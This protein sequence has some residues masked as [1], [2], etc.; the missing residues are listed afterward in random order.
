M[1]ASVLTASIGMRQVAEAYC[2][3]T[4]YQALCASKHPGLG[5]S[6]AEMLQAVELA[7]ALSGL[8][9]TSKALTQYVREFLAG[10]TDD[11]EAKT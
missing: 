10:Q 6:Q 4:Q 8:I 9:N 11:Q 7:E 5:L 2:Q 1:Q 3:G